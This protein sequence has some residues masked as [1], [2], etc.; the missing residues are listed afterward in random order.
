MKKILVSIANYGDGQLPYLNQIIT[1]FKSYKDFDVTINVHT[2]VDL[3][4]DGINVI[5][6][7]DSIKSLLTF[8][9]RSEFYDQQEDFDLFLY[10]ENDMLIKE[11][12]IK[13]FIKYDDK[14]P[15]DT[16]IGFL[17][18]ELKNNDD[19]IYLLEMN[20]HWGEPIKSKNLNIVNSM[21]F[22]AS[23]VHQG[24]WLLSK[25]KLKIAMTSG[26]Y[27][28]EINSLE[29]GAS[30]IFEDWSELRGNIKKVFPQNKEDLQRCFIHHL[31][32]KYASKN[33]PAWVGM[34]SYE[35]FKRL[36]L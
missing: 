3:N 2:T 32:N 35:L 22:Q 1:E 36:Q 23:N 17:R 14:L 12:A 6:Y 8:K 7:P 21:Y 18:Y 19:N 29:T 33:D 4:I 28:K 31:S 13:T 25:E 15:Q 20:P 34:S 10:D 30:G 16:C 27:F 26:N 11:D 9:H 5:K 24:C